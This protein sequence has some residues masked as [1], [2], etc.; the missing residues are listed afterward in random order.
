MMKMRVARLNNNGLGH[1]S[2]PWRRARIPYL[3]ALTISHL[4]QAGQALLLVRAVLGSLGGTA[5]GF[6]IAIAEIVVVIISAGELEILLGLVGGRGGG[7]LL[8]GARPAGSGA[9]DDEEQEQDL[10]GGGGDGQRDGQPAVMAQQQARD[11]VDHADGQDNAAQPL[12]DIAHPCLTLHLQVDDMVAPA[13]DGLDGERAHQQNAQV[14]VGDGD[15][16]RVDEADHG[17]DADR[18]AAQR[19]DGPVEIEGRRSWGAEQEDSERVEDQ[20]GEDHQCSVEMPGSTMPCL[21]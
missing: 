5:H 3:H 2:S 18:D 17:R 11:D 6:F 8:H 13:E 9:A 20:E 19:V 14:L 4:V 12:V 21:A 10:K 7:A 1:I 16:A 15:G